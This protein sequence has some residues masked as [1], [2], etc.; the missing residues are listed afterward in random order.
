[1][2]AAAAT[3]VYWRENWDKAFPPD[4]LKSMVKA[5]H[6]IHNRTFVCIEITTKEMFKVWIELLKD[7]NPGIVTNDQQRT[8]LPGPCKLYMCYFTSNHMNVQDFVS[9]SCIV[10]TYVQRSCICFHGLMELRKSLTGT[11]LPYEQLTLLIIS[12]RFIPRNFGA[13]FELIFISPTQKEGKLLRGV[14]VAKDINFN[15]CIGSTL[16]AASQN[17]MKKKCSCSLEISNWKSI[18]VFSSPS[19]GFIFSLPC[20]TFKGVDMGVINVPWASGRA[21]D[22]CKQKWLIADERIAALTGPWLHKTED[23]GLKDAENLSFLSI[24]AGIDGIHTIDY[25]NFTTLDPAELQQILEPSA[26]ASE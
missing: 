5:E 20:I 3:V 8:F 25:A 16:F 10:P 1:M 14:L 18:G 11:I 17:H 19:D 9:I 6:V 22:I 21:F 12:S 15:H 13:S 24:M 26:R 2:A 7:N 4:A 23:K